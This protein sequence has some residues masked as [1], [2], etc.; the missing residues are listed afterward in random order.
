MSGIP[1]SEGVM[2]FAEH[3]CRTLEC[4]G[5]AAGRDTALD[6]VVRCFAIQSGVALRFPP[7][8]KGEALSA[9][10][11]ASD[12]AS[13]SKAV[14]RSASHRTPGFGA[15]LSAARPRKFSIAKAG[16]LPQSRRVGTTERCFENLSNTPPRVTA[17]LH[18]LH[19]RHQVGAVPQQ[20]SSPI[21]RFAVPRVAATGGPAR[22]P[23]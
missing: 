22:T 5:K 2:C 21:F 1:Q 10:A 14:W 23:F 9:L 3:D 4:G 17:P 16:W 7:H 8:S 13:Q 19:A 15:L 18:P 20:E 6:C 12:G 11:R